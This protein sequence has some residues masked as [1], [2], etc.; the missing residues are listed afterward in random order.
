MPDIS[1][2]RFLRNASLGAA[3]VGTAAVVGPAAFNVAT[4]SGDVKHA[5]NGAGVVQP[6]A[7]KPGT[8]VV[9]EIVDASSGTIAIYVGTRKITYVNRDVAAQL[10]QA[11]Q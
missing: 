4:A 10:F 2:R 1:R 9:A 11:A 5:A 6:V 3:A 7:V 8:K